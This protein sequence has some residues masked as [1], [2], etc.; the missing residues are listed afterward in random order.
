MTKKGSA[1]LKFE[2][3]IDENELKEVVTELV[4]RRF[5]GDY[6]ADRN[7]QKRLIADAVKEVIYSQKEQIINMCVNRAST[8]ITKKTLPK[9]IEKFDEK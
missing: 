8:E 9:L 3:D 1:N 2:I 5:I 6:V 4:A 7:L